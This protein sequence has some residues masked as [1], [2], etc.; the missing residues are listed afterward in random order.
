[1]FSKTSSRVVHILCFS[2]SS[3]SR[4]SF[5]S[6]ANYLEIQKVCGHPLLRLNPDNLEIMMNVIQYPLFL[7]NLCN[8]TLFD[9]YFLKKDFALYFI[10]LQSFHVFISNFLRAKEKYKLH[11]YASQVVHDV[12][13]LE[14]RC[15]MSQQCETKSVKIKRST[16]HS[17]PIKAM[18]SK[19][20]N[21][22]LVF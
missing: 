3:S 4:D 11:F 10:R 1:M 13:T 19:Y 9:I 7:R 20:Q 6:S 5:F 17:F 12:P 2:D 8:K 21:P 16:S 14:Y 18:F 22:P 15:E